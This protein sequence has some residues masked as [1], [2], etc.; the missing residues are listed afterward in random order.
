VP[1]SNGA[2]TAKTQRD[3]ARRDAPKDHKEGQKK[4]GNFNREILETHEKGN[5]EEK[6]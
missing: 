6:P 4:T 3:P 1:Q 2:G 5:E